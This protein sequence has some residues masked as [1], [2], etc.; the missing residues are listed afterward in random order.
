MSKDSHENVLPPAIQKQVDQADSII[1]QLQQTEGEPAPAPQPA[2]EPAPA[3]APTEIKVGSPPAPAPAPAAPAPAPQP[4]NDPAS[5]RTDWKQKYL[6][7]QGKYDKEVPRLHE[8]LRVANAGMH[9]LQ[10]QLGTLT[11][12]VA[13]M[14]EV[15]KAPPVPTTPLVSDEEIERF[16]P[17]LVDVMKRVATEAV[18]PYDDRKVGELATTVQ[19]QGE[20]ASHLET[21][22]AESA[23]NRLYERLDLAVP[24]WNVI[25]KDPIF[26]TWLGTVEPLTGQL[27]G[28][29]LRAAFDRNDSE[30]VVAFFKSFQEEHVVEVPDPN[31]AAPPAD[32]VVPETPAEPQQTLEELVAPGTPKTGPT[33]AHDESGNGRI[34]TQTDITEFYAYRNEFI[35][36]NPNKDIPDNVL[37]LE[38]DLIAAQSEG[39]IR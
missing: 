34:W 30:R 8:D 19:K 36:K 18:A 20:K 39:R 29:L 24:G 14:Q 9:G 37:A 35:K 26:V 16:G 17:D 23:R 6:V 1:A 7:L 38:R 5:E 10:D 2:N 11:A 32:P 31:N 27:R 33:D 4:A 3:P 12:T 21:G 28:N 22:V 13:A 25:N 15:N